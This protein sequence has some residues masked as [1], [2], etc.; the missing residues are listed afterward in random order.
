VKW[1]LTTVAVVTVSVVLVSQNAVYAQ[2][3]GRGGGGFSGGQ[4]YNSSGRSYGNSARNHGNSGRRHGN[5]GRT[6]GSTGRGGSARAGGGRGYNGA[7]N[8]RPAPRGFYSNYAKRFSHGHW[9]RHRHSSWGARC[10]HARYRCW[11][12]WCPV[13][14]CSYYW[15]GPYN[16]YFPVT[17]CPTGSYDY[18]EPQDTGSPEEQAPYEEPSPV[19]TGG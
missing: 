7:R 10:W 6:Y 9:F 13:T 17:Y 5:A 2:R 14:C 12:R 4:S 11:C 1:F 19:A 18:E 3:G 15:C 8:G 16:C